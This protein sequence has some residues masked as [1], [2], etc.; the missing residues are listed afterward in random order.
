MGVGLRGASKGDV[1]GVESDAAE[2]MT[3]NEVA[4]E[5]SE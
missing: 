3:G 5:F 1:I 2:E 4:A